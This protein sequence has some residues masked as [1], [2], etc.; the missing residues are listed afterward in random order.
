MNGLSTSP[1]ETCR[2]LGPSWPRLDCF[3]R[4]PLFLGGSEL[5]VSCLLVG[6]PVGSLVGWYPLRFDSGS[7]SLPTRVRLHLA[8]GRHP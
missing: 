3:W 2:N 5:L 1:G 7:E 8:P 6:V 4:A